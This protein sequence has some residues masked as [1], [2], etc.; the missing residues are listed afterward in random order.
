MDTTLSLQPLLFWIFGIV[1][2]LGIYIFKDFKENTLNRFNKNENSIEKLQANRTDNDNKVMLLS[3]SITNMVSKLSELEV[4]FKEY[5]RYSQKALEKREEYHSYIE[6]IASNLM[7]QDQ[8][9][10]MLGKLDKIANK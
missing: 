3:Q 9:K 7:T 5:M 1:G 2:V 8:M 4:D 10:D 6:K